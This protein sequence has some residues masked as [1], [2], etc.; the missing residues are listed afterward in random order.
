[1][2]ARAADEALAGVRS[3]V[4]FIDEDPTRI[5]PDYS[6]F[7]KGKLRGNAGMGFILQL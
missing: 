2:S 6:A 1:M 3:A 5:V 7:R 4:V